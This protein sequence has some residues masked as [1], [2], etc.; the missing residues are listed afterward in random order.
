MKATLEFSLPEEQTELQDALN[1]TRW[2]GL[3]Q[4]L[5]QSL[6][7]HEGSAREARQLLNDI[8]SGEGLDLFD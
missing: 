1:G 7:H 4:D 5:E 8:V 3:L 6:K 2:R